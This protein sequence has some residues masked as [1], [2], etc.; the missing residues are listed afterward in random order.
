MTETAETLELGD[1]NPVVLSR[2]ETE[3]LCL[4]AARGAGF[5]WGLAEEAG[6][7]AGWLAAHGMD[8]TGPLLAHLT[9][10]LGLPADTGTPRPEPGHWQSA[11]NHALCPIK[12]GAAMCDA[13]LLADGPF[14]RDTRLDTV[15][16]PILLLPFLVR[17]AQISASAVVIDWQVGKLRIAANGAFDRLAADRWI[18][19]TD[20]AMTLWRATDIRVDQGG[21]IGLAAISAASLN[22]LSALALKTTVPA[23]DASRRGAGSA[24]ADN[25]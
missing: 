1:A 10:R 22:G 9:A 20:L 5:S 8:G 14:G 24:T 3:S 4:K 19:M 11:D 2:N 13:A 17:A 21:R 16:Y 18:G 7:A 15:A 25:D 23:T 6:F 12:L